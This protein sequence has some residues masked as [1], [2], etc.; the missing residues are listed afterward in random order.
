[1]ARPL[2]GVDEVDP[3]LEH[4]PDK[5]TRLPI[6]SLDPESPASFQGQSPTRLFLT[7]P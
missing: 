5:W 6:T 2:S 4:P 7:T 3:S 1:A